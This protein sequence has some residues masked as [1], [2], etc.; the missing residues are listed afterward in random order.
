MSVMQGNIQ[1]VKIDTVFQSFEFARY[2]QGSSWNTLIIE[3]YEAGL[4]YNLSTSEDIKYRLEG[5]TSDNRYIYHAPDII[6]GNTLTFKS[7]DEYMCCVSGEYNV[8]VAI[9]DLTG[10]KIDILCQNIVIKVE[11][12][13]FY[14]SNIMT[15][16]E[17]SELNIELMN[18]EVNVQKCITATEECVEAINNVGTATTDCETATTDSVNQTALCK[19]ATDG[20]ELVNAVPNKDNKAGVF[21]VDVTDRNGVTITSENLKGTNAV[22]TGSTP[23]PDDSY[24][25]WVDPNAGDVEALGCI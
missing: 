7:I 10:K 5:A 19:T 25:V 22:W 11:P 9:F 2:K 24:M 4:P 15:V 17:M 14:Q 21:K 13:S 20:A 23:P 6:D 8:S 18:A 3:L 16:D 12:N 1:T